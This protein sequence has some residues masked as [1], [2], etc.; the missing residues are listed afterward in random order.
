MAF[1]TYTLGDGRAVFLG[2]STVWKTGQEIDGE[3]YSPG[4]VLRHDGPRDES[5]TEAITVSRLIALAPDHGSLILDRSRALLHELR[6]QMKQHSLER[7][8]VYCELVADFEREIDDA[9]TLLTGVPSEHHP[10]GA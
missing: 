8:R 6:V 5:W 1:A 4:W 2:V 7:E 9:I 10:R 3:L